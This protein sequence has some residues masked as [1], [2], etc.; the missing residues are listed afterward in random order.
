MAEVTSPPPTPPRADLPLPAHPAAWEHS[1]L[2]LT[3]SEVLLHTA[4]ADSGKVCACLVV[5][6]GP[7]A[8]L[9]FA[10]DAA[11]T[12]IGRLPDNEAQI[13]SPGISRR[14]A[15]LQLQGDSVV[16]HDLGSANGTLLNGVRLEKPTALKDGDLVRLGEVT[17][18]FYDRQS[19]DAAVHDRLYR[20]AT[21]DAGTELY[22]RRYVL[23]VL[24]RELHRARRSGQPLSVVALDLDHFKAVNDRWGH[25]AGDTVLRVAAGVVSANARA[26]DTVGRLGGEEFIVVMPD[27]PLAAATEAADRMRLALAA[28]VVSIEQPGATAPVLHRQTVSLGVVQFEPAMRSVSELLSAADQMLYAA[29]R[30]GRNCIGRVTAASSLA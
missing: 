12:V 7:Q 22:T 5:Y 8:G 4:P 20:I 9:R 1:T 30:A 2:R 13:D 21:V 18:K 17:L 24:E 26:G 29:K 16:L 11:R 19:L 15:E 6:T 14:H 28:R 25:A 3:K 27:T 10:L 23:E